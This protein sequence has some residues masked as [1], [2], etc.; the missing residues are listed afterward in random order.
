MADMPQRFVRRAQFVDCLPVP[1]PLFPIPIYPEDIDDTED[2]VEY[3]VDSPP[4]SSLAS[5]FFSHFSVTG[6]F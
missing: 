4:S 1:G 3:P 6:L 2:F 5:R